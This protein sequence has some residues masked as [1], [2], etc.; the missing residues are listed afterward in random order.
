MQEL[1]KIPNHISSINILANPLTDELGEN[2]KKEIIYVLPH[3]TK[4]N[5]SPVS[6]EDRI[7]FEKER[8]EKIAQ[9]EKEREEAKKAEQEPAD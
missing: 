5:K 7:T 9:E 8:L 4:I 2:L 3:F 6:E 1:K